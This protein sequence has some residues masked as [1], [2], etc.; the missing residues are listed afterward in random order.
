MCPDNNDNNNNDDND[1][2]ILCSF[3]SS[4]IPFAA[5]YEQNGMD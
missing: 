3:E 1:N 4:W 5:F 2:D